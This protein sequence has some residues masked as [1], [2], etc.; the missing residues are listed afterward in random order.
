[1]QN[2]S[3]LLL[4]RGA[5]ATEEELLRILEELRTAARA[6]PSAGSRILMS[7]LMMLMTTSSSISVKPWR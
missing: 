7:K 4:A 1:M 6:D 5:R 3:S 2:G